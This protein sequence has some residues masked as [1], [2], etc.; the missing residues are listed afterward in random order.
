MVCTIW[1]SGNKGL[2]YILTTGSLSSRT[3]ERD[4]HSTEANWPVRAHRL[5]HR[6]ALWLR[7][8]AP[9]LRKRP[10]SRHFQAACPEG[11]PGST[12]PEAAVTP[13]LLPEISPSPPYSH[14]LIARFAP[15]STARA[16]RLRRSRFRPRVPEPLSPARAHA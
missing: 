7:G 6:F 15:E 12:P 14:P 3:V 2:M 10:R 9:A 5:L 8:G 11:R 1:L 4:A 16:R 13:R